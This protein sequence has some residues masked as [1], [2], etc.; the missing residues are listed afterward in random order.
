VPYTGE[1][2]KEG[3]KSAYLRARRQS[4]LCRA[5]AAKP[6][7]LE[8]L[9]QITLAALGPA[10]SETDLEQFMP[11]LQGWGVRH[12]LLDEWVLKLVVEAVVEIQLEEVQV[13]AD[14][15]TWEQRV[16]RYWSTGDQL[17]LYGH[18]LQDVPFAFS[19]EWNPAWTKRHDAEAQIRASFELQLKEYLN[20]REHFAA[21]LGWVSTPETRA[22]AKGGDP[23]FHLSVLA[24]F[25]VCG[26]S[27]T[28]IARRHKISRSA[29]EAAC[30]KTAESIGLTR[31]TI[32]PLLS[33][34]G[35]KEV[36]D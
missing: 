5:A 10:A 2:H 26:R 36:T 13:E 28:D 24:E 6:G 19:A 1:L 27:H 3:P 35:P 30:R 14:P 7:L 31:R 11:A 22:R 33:L 25:Q 8:E 34:D 20:N 15:A 17:R 12:H 4:F 32:G 21:E 23:N 29:V 9:Y 18:S 16:I